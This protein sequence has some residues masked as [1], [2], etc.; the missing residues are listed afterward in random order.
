MKTEESK[1]SYPRSVEDIM[2]DLKEGEML[3]KVTFVADGFREIYITAIRS[4]FESRNKWVN[5]L[6]LTN[7]IV[8]EGRAVGYEWYTSDDLIRKAER[9]I[10]RYEPRKAISVGGSIRFNRE[11]F[12][13]EGKVRIMSVQEPYCNGDGEIE[14]RNPRCRIAL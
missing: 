12:P 10:M 7:H 11:N 9:S 5:K 3:L 4:E 1:I 6:N 13:E 2:S 14:W 8:D